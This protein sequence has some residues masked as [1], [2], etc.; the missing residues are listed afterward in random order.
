M[1]DETAVGG[2]PGGKTL[3]AQYTVLEGF[4]TPAYNRAL[5][6]AK[7]T[8]PE[9]VPPLGHNSATMYPTPYQDVGAIGLNTVSSKVSNVLFPPG[10]AFFEYTI[11][12]AS[13]LKLDQGDPKRKK[14]ITE[15]LAKRERTIMA[16]FDELNARPKLGQAITHAFGFGNALAF[17]QKDGLRVWGITNF[18]VKRDTFGDML[19]AI[20]KDVVSPD[21]LS[22]KVRS[23]LGL[24]GT[25]PQVGETPSNDTGDPQ[26]ELY[27]GCILEGDKYRV[28]QEINGKVLPD[29]EVTV[30]KEL[31]PFIAIRLYPT[32]NDSYGRGYVG[33]FYGLLQSL[34]KL[35]AAVIQKGGAGAKVLF[36]NAPGSG[37]TTRQL[38]KAP[39]GAYLD[40]DGTKVTPIQM[41]NPV[42]DNTLLQLI[43]RIEKHLQMVFM[44][45]ASAQ[46]DAER[47]TAEEIRALISDIQIVLG[48][49][50]AL[51]TYELQLP[52]V[53]LLDAQLVREDILDPL[54]EFKKEI[55]LKVVT[56][57]AAL[58]RGQDTQ[59]LAQ[60]FQIISTLPQPIAQQ[61]AMAINASELLSRIFTSL[62]INPDALVVPDAVVQAR[63][64]AQQQQEAANSAAVAAAPHMAKAAAAQQGGGANSQ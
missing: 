57:M 60:A 39:N 12:E 40:G 23:F 8:I 10:E 9:L 62:G 54:D 53:K 13:L 49:I 25:N 31:C 33:Q 59:R 35:Y 45:N 5:K 37:I 30:P 43:D 47:V 36:A 14:N 11:D 2:T 15:G 32:D 22:S 63:Q 19:V 17:L 51:L 58:G 1:A 46:R 28:Y 61:I 52:I 3:K 7:L 18:V 20:A 27:S 42:G 38:S 56:G 6:V 55:K 24:D 21:A 4:R 64:Q 29:T 48:D 26:L 50:Y 44:M 41:A 16:R 34:E